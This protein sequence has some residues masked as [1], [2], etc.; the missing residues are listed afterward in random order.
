VEPLAEKM[1]EVVIE[2]GVRPR[3]ELPSILSLADVL[4][5]PGGPDAFNDY[6]FPSK[7]P[8]FL[9]SGRPV[10]LPRTNIG[11]HLQDEAEC[12][13]LEQ[14]DALEIA[15]KLEPLLLDEGRRRRIGA[16]GRAFA[17]EQLSWPKAARDLLTFYERLIH[18][19]GV[20]VDGHSEMDQVHAHPQD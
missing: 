1:K 8:E 12:I 7:L 6:R 14:G 9:A 16:A 5:Q 10:M 4:V 18:R 13:L 19:R 17:L 2:L 15:R 3:S 20:P 11:R